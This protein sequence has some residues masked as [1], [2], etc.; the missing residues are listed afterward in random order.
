M[1]RRHRNGYRFTEKTHSKRGV[2]ALFLSIISIG[3]L[4]AAVVSSFDSRGNG[5]MYLGS[6]GVTSMLIGICALVLAVKSLGEENSF[7]LFPYLS[8]LCS[9]LITG[10]WVALYAI[11]FW[12]RRRI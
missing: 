2:A 8:T 7:K 9:L 1:A 3:I 11:G 4:A 6:A 5:S 12:H 10:I